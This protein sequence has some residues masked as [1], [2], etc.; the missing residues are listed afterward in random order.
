METERMSPAAMSK[1]QIQECTKLKIFLWKQ[2]NIIIA[3]ISATLDRAPKSFTCSV[4]PVILP[5]KKVV[6]GMISTQISCINAKRPDIAAD[7]V[8]RAIE[9]CICSGVCNKIVPNQ[10]HTAIKYRYLIRAREDN[11][12]NF[13]KQD[14]TIPPIVKKNNPKII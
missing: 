12:G 8:Q 6:L 2:V 7:D 14:E 13:V 11:N 4:R 5:Q 1:A 10:N 3:G 9:V